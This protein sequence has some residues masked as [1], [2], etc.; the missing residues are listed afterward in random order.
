MFEIKYNMQYVSSSKI[1]LLIKD[2][3][4]YH[5]ILNK[6]NINTI[7]NDYNYIQKKL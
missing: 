5:L 6:N 4:V 2:E 1:K 7:L 3:N